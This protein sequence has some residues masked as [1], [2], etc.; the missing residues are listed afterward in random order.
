LAVTT[1]TSD[2]TEVG[3]NA[4]LLLTNTVVSIQAYA[5]S[6]EDVKDMIMN[7]RNNIITD[8]KNFYNFSLIYP[9][10]TSPLNPEPNRHDKIVSQTADFRIS[11]ESE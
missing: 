7:T 11:L 10:A 5:D 3:A 9:I 1:L 2:S 8:K 6:T 4:D